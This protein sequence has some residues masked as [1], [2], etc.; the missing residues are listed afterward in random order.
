MF[1]I[2]VV[3]IGLTVRSIGEIHRK[4]KFS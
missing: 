4:L 1:A 3:K 2:T